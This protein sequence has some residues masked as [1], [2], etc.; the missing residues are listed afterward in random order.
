[1][2]LTTYNTER[3][4]AEYSLQPFQET[5]LRSKF[6]IVQLIKVEMAILMPWTNSPVSVWVQDD[7]DLWLGKVTAKSTVY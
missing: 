4:K 1:M 6:Y 3:L 5:L 2:G 7:G